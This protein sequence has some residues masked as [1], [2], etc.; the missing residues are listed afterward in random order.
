MAK[1]IWSPKAADQLDQIAQY[2]SVDSEFYAKTVMNR[3][4]GATRRLKTFPELGSI[5]PNFNNPRLRE[6]RV[7][8][9][10]LVYQLDETIET[11]RIVGVVHGARLLCDDLLD[12]DR[13][14]K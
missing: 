1:V 12:V 14:K 7:F 5:V 6:I 3:I 10:R 4:I 13:E 2:I 8:S 11:V 9:Y